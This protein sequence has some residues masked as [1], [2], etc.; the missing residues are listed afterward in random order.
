MRLR[1]RWAVV[2]SLSALTAVLVAVPAQFTAA[3]QAPSPGSATGPALGGAKQPEGGGAPVGVGA[4][5][6]GFHALKHGGNAIDAAVAAASAL[7]VT[8]PVVAGPGGGGF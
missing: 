5:Q 7:G 2:S 6:A 1:R 4:S 8:I 3:A